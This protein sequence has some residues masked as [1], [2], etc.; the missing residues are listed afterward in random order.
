MMNYILTF[1][2]LNTIYIFLGQSIYNFR[3]YKSNRVMKK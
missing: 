1:N 3:L 2:K